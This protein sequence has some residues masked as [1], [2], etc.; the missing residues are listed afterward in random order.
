MEWRRFVTYLWND[1]RIMFIVT[2]IIIDYFD[3]ISTTSLPVTRLL[4]VMPYW[5]RRYFGIDI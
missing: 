3:C 1:P 2:L 5:K 4:Y